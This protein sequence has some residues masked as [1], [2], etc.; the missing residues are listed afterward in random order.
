MLR[1]QPR[2]AGG[3][4]GGGGGPGGFEIDRTS[5]YLTILLYIKRDDI[6]IYLLPFY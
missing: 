2:G 1:N 4:G 6:Y 5:D 3:G